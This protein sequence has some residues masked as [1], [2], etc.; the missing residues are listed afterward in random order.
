M[1][2]LLDQGTPAPLRRHLP[3]HSVD[4]LSEKGGSD[5]DNGELLELAER[6]GYEML[7]TTDPSLRHQQNPE[8]RKIGIVIL[9][10]TNWTAISRH[11]LEIGQ[12]TA[13]MRPGRVVEV[14]IQAK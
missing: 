6:E 10:S 1:R 13:A 2:L 9:L 5:K 12:A 7:V 3:A 14:P 4:T 8:G 11:V